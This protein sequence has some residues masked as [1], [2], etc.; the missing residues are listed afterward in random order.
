MMKKSIFIVAFAIL[1]IL[2]L[3]LFTGCQ[4]RS[5]ERLEREKAKLIALSDAGVQSENVRDLEIEL[6]KEWGVIL[7]DITFESGG[8]EYEYEIDAYSGEIL[9]ER[10][11]RDR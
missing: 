6:D 3:A 8:F 4:D 7:Y 10:S 1:L 9:F 5:G 11:E 2:S